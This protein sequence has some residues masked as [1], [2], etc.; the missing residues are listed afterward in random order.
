MPTAALLDVVVCIDD[1]YEDND[2]RQA[3]PTGAAAEI[4]R[5]PAAARPAASMTTRNGSRSTSTRASASPST[6][7]RQRSTSTSGS[8]TAPASGYRRRRA[9]I[10][11]EQPVVH[12]RHL[13]NT[14]VRVGCGGERLQAGVDATNENR[15]PAR[16]RQYEDRRPYRR[17]VRDVPTT[18][19]NTKI[20]PTTRPT[21]PVYPA[22]SDINLKLR[23]ELRQDLDLTARRVRLRPD[24]VRRRASCARRAGQSATTTLDL[25]VPSARADRRRRY[26]VVVQAGPVATPYGNN[27]QVQ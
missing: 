22:T 21:G 4:L 14:G 7:S 26:Y 23:V 16:R 6:S 8:P 19:D 9:W 18:L 27:I 24:A 12:A 10:R 1:T 5:V 13:R 11:R 17:R 15:D 2:P 3:A 20:A 25:P